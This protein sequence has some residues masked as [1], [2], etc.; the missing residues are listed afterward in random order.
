VSSKLRDQVLIEPPGLLGFGVH[1]Q[2][3]AADGVAEAGLA[4]AGDPGNCIQQQ[5]RTEALAFMAFVHPQAGEQRH[6]LGVAARTAPQ[7]LG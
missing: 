6:G 7:P 5:G 1:Q 3:A 2:A 4:E